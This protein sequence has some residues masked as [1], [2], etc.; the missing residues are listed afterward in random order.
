MLRTVRRRP[1]VILAL[2]L[3]LASCTGTKGG[4]PSDGSAATSA[5]TTSPPPESGANPGSPAPAPGSQEDDQELIA[6]LGGTLAV[7]IEN[8]VVMLSP[9]GSYVELVDDGAN[10]TS[11]QPVWSPDGSRLAWSYIGPDGESVRVRSADGETL[12]SDASASVPFYMQWD[13]SGQKLAYLRPSPPDAVVQDD[14]AVG[15]L[16]AGLVE[17]G[18]PVRPL[19]TGSPFYLSWAPEAN[20][21]I[22][23]RNGTELILLSGDADVA[24]IPEGAGP[25]T[26]PVWTGPSTVVVSDTDSIDEL[27]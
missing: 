8:L 21:L 5:T 7:T 1:I 24:E 13:S 14:E 16:Q 22:A 10:G 19:T 26:A 4:N 9:D 17:P 12:E 15:A 23:F 3:L 2:A 11:S 25:Y 18:E 27:N 6:E 20:D